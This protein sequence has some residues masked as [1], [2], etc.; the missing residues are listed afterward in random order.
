MCLQNTFWRAKNAVSSWSSDHLVRNHRLSHGCCR[1]TLCQ[2]LHLR[3]IEGF[4]QGV[5]EN[6]V[7]FV[8]DSVRI[9]LAKCFGINSRVQLLDPMDE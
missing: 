3:I 7:L 8:L 6:F 5:M 1:E 4:G 2:A 9:H